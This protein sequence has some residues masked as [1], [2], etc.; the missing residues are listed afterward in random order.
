MVTAA[1]A[2]AFDRLS[3]AGSERRRPAFILAEL[4]SR[5]CRLVVADVSH[6]L[7]SERRTGSPRTATAARSIQALAAE[8]EDVAALQ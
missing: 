8:H 3:Q 7:L 1:V 4:V 6:A 2:S 5:S